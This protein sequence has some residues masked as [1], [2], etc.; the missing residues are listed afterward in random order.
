MW[1]NDGAT[2]DANDFFRKTAETYP[3]RI[4]SR[5]QQTVALN[6]DVLRP[7]MQ[8]RF[9]AMQYIYADV[10]KN[11]SKYL[12]YLTAPK[13]I[14]PVNR[15]LTTSNLNISNG[16]ATQQKSTNSNAISY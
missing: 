8:K 10:H 6:N 9:A 14:E 3:E 13:P 12:Q 7:I 16:T 4:G 1:S 2:L 5:M 11:N 15:Y